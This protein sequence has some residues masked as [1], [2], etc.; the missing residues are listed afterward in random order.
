MAKK[1]LPQTIVEALALARPLIRQEVE[2]AIREIVEPRFAKLEAK[3]NLLV[4][5][6]AKQWQWIEAFVTSSEAQLARHEAWMTKYGY[7]VKRVGRV[8]LVKEPSADESSP[9]KAH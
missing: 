3:V 5:M 7:K 4:D 1:V 9:V 6:M 2:D 8:L